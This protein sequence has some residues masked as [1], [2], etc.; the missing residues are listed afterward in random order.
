M[1]I[2]ATLIALPLLSPAPQLAPE[3][4]APPPPAGEDVSALRVEDYRPHVEYFAS[5]AMEG[6]E[7]GKEGGHAAARYAAKHFEKLGLKPVTSDG[8]FLVPF[9]L[10]DLRC[11]NTAGLLPGTDPGLAD[12]ILVIGGH[13]DHAGIGGPGAMGFPGQIHNGAD[14]NASG[15]CGVLELA[16]YFAAHP[17]RRPILFMTFSAEERGLL[18]SHDFVVN[19][20]VG[21]DRMRAMLNLDMIGRSRNDYCFVGGLGTAEEFHP[22]LDGLLEES[23]M[24]LEIVN[25]GEAPSDN[26]SFYHEGVPSLFFFTHIHEDYHMPGDD[27]EKINYE[28]AIRILGLVRDIAVQINDMEGPLTYQEAPGMGMPADFNERMSE[29]FQRI[30]ELRN[31]RGSLGVTPGELRDGGIEV[32]EVRPGSAADE[33]GIRAGDVLLSIEGMEVGTVAQLRRALGGRLEGD[34]VSIVLLRNG[35]QQTVR[36]VLAK[37]PSQRGN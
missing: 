9:E 14:D 36:A 5:D 21:V 23:S 20:P 17:T 35:A 16:E 27:A 7:S 3:Q 30:M 6:R 28:G 11:Y 2:T 18:G 31:R 29:H 19:G 26:T 34:P 8:S 12:E 25:S 33:A 4:Q 37:R 32:A 1:L 15:S 13:H 22:L 24:D 10:G